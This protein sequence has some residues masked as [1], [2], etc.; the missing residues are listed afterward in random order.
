MS[1]EK[2]SVSVSGREAEKQINE[3]LRLSAYEVSG[4]I[5]KEC[6]NSNKY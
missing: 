4:T 1:E 2:K 5:N 3:Q 6:N